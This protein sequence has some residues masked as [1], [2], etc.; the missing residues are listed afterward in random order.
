MD[1]YGALLE[2]LECYELL[3]TAKKVHVI[4]VKERKVHGP[5]TKSD[6][7]KIVIIVYPDGRRRTVSYPKFLV[8]EHLGRELDP[9]LETIDHWDSDF[10]NNDLSNLKIIPRQQHSA[11]DTRRVKLV[12]F[13]CVW[14]N[15]EFERS[16]RLVRDKSKKKCAGPFCSR[17]CVGKYSRSRQ[18]KLVDK[19]DV[20]PAVDSEY[21]KKK[22]V[23]DKK[24]KKKYVD[25]K[26]YKK[27]VA[28][29]GLRQFLINSMIDELY[30][31]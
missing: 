1:K 19:F 21:Y 8:E 22:Y 10:N 5:Y 26:K 30:H 27:K 17:I 6:G 28:S 11:N 29:V 2:D 23:K 14:C 31:S 15:K 12:K 25:S 13:N 16:P 24:Y 7:R 4:S 18:L 9:N 3:A 20:Q